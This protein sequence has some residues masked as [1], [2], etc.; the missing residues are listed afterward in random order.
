MVFLSISILSNAFLGTGT[1]GGAGP[2]SPL[3]QAERP[4]SN[5][6]LANRPARRLVEKVQI[7]GGRR[8]LHGL[9]DA[10]IAA[11]IGFRDDLLARDN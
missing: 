1:I 6:L 8:D 4:D 2:R 10:K 7:P 3:R 11:R 5:A 9:A